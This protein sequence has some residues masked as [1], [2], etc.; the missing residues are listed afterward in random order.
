M[1]SQRGIVLVLILLALIVGVGV[2][3]V[4]K[5]G[6]SSTQLQREAHNHRVLLEARNALV[7]HAVSRSFRPT[8]NMLFSLPCPD[9]NDDGLAE[10][11][12]GNAAGTTGQ[13]QRLGRL[14]WKTLGLDDLR[15]ANGERL[16]YAVSSKY[17]A[18]TLND[19]IN[20]TTGIGTITL[21]NSTSAMIHDGSSSDTYNPNAAGAIALVIAPGSP[22]TRQDSPQPQD[23][24]C[25]GDSCNSPYICTTVPLTATPKCN[26]V[27]YLDIAM[28]EDNA[29][30]IDANVV[31]AANTNGFIQGPIVMANNLLVNDMIMPLT[32]NDIMPAMSQ[33]VALEASLCLNDY[34]AVNLGRYPWPAP[35]CQQANMPISWGDHASALFGRIADTPFTNTQAAN[36]AMST[37]WGPQCNIRA[38]TEKWWEAWRMHVF[39]AVADARRP[40]VLPLT[41]ALTTACAPSDVT[42]CLPLQSPN[43]VLL[44][45]SKPYVILVGGANLGVS[46][47][48]QRRGTVHDGDAA[49]Y[50]EGSNKNLQ[51]MIIGTPPVTCSPQPIPCSPLS[52][53]YRVT[54]NDQSSASNDTV[55]TPN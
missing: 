1:K 16:W 23:R 46:T 24:S 34:A 9:M 53:C 5:M 22:L 3:L 49:N 48:I 35:I 55:I 10:P 20:P 44:G 47:P 30:F 19:D 13:S 39:V 14:P 50:L 15:D 42:G 38:G 41:D 2:L 36:S 32:Y 29:T 43:G 17:K 11:A 25:I 8:E 40:D 51:G 12:C 33:R 7:A 6:S 52:S 18:N 37:Q 45:Q 4:A 31:R 26:P 27:N 54:I 21:R 28:G